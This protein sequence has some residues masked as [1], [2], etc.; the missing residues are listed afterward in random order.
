MEY[1]EKPNKIDDVFHY[2]NVAVLHF[3]SSQ[4]I[5]KITRLNIDDDII[6]FK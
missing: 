1:N 5:D 6:F 2:K 3:F 4:E